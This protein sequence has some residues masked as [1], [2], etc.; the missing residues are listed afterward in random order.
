MF[1]ILIKP[2]T[3][4]RNF[5]DEFNWKKNAFISLLP[6]FDPFIIGKPNQIC[7]KIA[8]RKFHKKSE[9]KK[10][11]LINLKI[12]IDQCVMNSLTSI[13]STTYVH[14]WIVTGRWFSPR[15]PLFTT[16][17]TDRHDITEILLK[18]ALNTITLSLS[19]TWDRVIITNIANACSSN[20]IHWSEHQYHV[21]D[22]L[23]SNL[24][25]GGSSIRTASLFFFFFVGSISLPNAIILANLCLFLSLSLPTAKHNLKMI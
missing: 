18:V 10:T 4:D 2:N 17:K 3:L 8:C 21:K 11:C 5:F 12:K 6:P 25:T 23:S 14:Q 15:T 9:E 16:N 19:T 13:P 7:F 1:F 22:L 24:S 20:S